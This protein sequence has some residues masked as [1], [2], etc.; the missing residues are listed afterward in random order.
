M[1][2]VHQLQIGERLEDIRVQ[3][4][5]SQSFVRRHIVLEFNHF[6]VETVLLRDRQSGTENFSVSAG[7]DTDLQRLNRGCLS[8]NREGQG[9]S[10]CRDKK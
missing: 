5:V 7:R 6:D 1:L 9:C 3:I 2:L 10:E 4:T 8:G